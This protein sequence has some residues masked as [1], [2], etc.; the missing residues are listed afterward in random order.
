VT[1]TSQVFVRCHSC[2]KE[3][4]YTLNPV[5]IAPT[6]RRFNRTI[7]PS[8]ADLVFSVLCRVKSDYCAGLLVL[9]P[10]L[11]GTAAIF[12]STRM[13]GVLYDPVANC[14]I[15]LRL[16]TAPSVRY[17]RVKANKSVLHWRPN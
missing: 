9:A 15:P 10:V 1:G 14:K 12:D 2:E 13:A 5:V 16:N 17:R 3:S 6:Q 7:I 4:V 8:H 11:P